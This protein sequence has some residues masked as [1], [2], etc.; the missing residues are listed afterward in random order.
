[1]TVC[2]EVNLAV[3]SV[4]VLKTNTLEIKSGSSAFRD[5]KLEIDLVGKFR[6][7]NVLNGKTAGRHVRFFYKL[8]YFT[9]RFRVRILE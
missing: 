6:I 7:V 3:L 5:G 1:M 9:L 2:K 8:S 4:F